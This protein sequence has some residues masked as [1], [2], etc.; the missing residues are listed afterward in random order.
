[1]TFFIFILFNILSTSYFFT[2]STSI[3]FTSSFFCITI[4]DLAQVATKTKTW[5]RN[6]SRCNWLSI[7]IQYSIYS[8]YNSKPWGKFSEYTMW[9]SHNIWGRGK[10]TTPTTWGADWDYY[11]TADHVVIILCPSLWCILEVSIVTF[12]LSTCFLYYTTQLT[13]TTG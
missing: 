13:I 3:G 9:M 4:L 10:D 5:E 6:K 12:C 1:M 11:S 2:S 8:I 7:K